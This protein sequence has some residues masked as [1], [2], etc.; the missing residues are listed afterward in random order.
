MEIIIFI[1]DVGTFSDKY[2]DVELTGKIFVNFGKSVNYI[3]Y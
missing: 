1:L 2:S 3:I